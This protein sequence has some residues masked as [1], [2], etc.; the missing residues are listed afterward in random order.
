MDL[1]IQY[2]HNDTEQDTPTKDSR[3]SNFVPLVAVGVAALINKKAQ[4]KK[5]AQFKLN[6]AN[7]N[8]M[9]AQNRLA[10]TQEYGAKK[11]A[12]EELKK[13]NAEQEKASQEVAKADEELKKASEGE[14]ATKQK[15]TM[16]I[17]GGV[18]VLGIVLYVALRK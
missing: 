14:S 17:V 4:K 6:V 2:F 16:L 3:Y 5:D 10:E 18:V 8:K 9:A 15:K 1:D 11:K 12:E 7:I 13:A